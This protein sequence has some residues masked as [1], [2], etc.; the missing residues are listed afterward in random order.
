ME[1]HPPTDL[2][3]AHLVSAAGGDEDALLRVQTLRLSALSLSGSLDKLELVTQ[4]SAL[5]LQ[6]N[7]LLSLAGI[8]IL[9]RL[10]TLHVGGNRLASLAPCAALRQLEYLDARDNCVGEEGV[11][12]LPRAL[13]MLT[14]SGNP[15][16]GAPG[17][18]GQLLALLPGLVELDKEPTPLAAA[19]G[20]ARAA[21]A[22]AAAGATDA[23]EGS[24]LREIAAGALA[25]SKARQAEAEA[26]AAA[27]KQ[28]RD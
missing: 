1:A 28:P 13:R 26:A 17:Y 22:A 7:C 4:L 23:G 27:A 16:C 11:Q 8:E 19:Q 3:L 15:C 12:R 24:G 10:R 2:S 5:Y 25:R 21:A 20:G 18:R 14:L 9:S 6:D